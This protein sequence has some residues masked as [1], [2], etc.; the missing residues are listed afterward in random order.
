MKISYLN[1][2]RHRQT[3]GTFRQKFH[4]RIGKRAEYLRLL[5][6]YA[7]RI[8]WIGLLCPLLKNWRFP[9]GKKYCMRA[10]SYTRLQS[11]IK[12]PTIPNEYGI[13]LYFLKSI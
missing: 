4:T 2:K 13:I 7:L 11:Y 10:L 12:N 5:P 1:L 3:P 8:R 9:L 6:A